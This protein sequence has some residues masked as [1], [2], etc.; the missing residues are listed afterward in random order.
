ML[1]VDATFL[2][3]ETGKVVHNDSMIEQ[4]KHSILISPWFYYTIAYTCY[5]TTLVQSLNHIGR[6]YCAFMYMYAYHDAYIAKSSRIAS[7]SA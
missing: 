5:V 6:L 1:D 3:L 2:M 4:H 7:K